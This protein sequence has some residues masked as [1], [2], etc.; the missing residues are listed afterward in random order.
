MFE[1]AQQIYNAYCLHGVLPDTAPKDD[2]R[3]LVSVFGGHTALL[4]TATRE[5]LSATGSISQESSSP[6]ASNSLAANPDFHPSWVTFARLEIQKWLI[7]RLQPFMG[8]FPA[9]AFA[10]D[11]DPSGNNNNSTIIP[12]FPT[13]FDSYTYP[14]TI[15]TLQTP[16]ALNGIGNQSEISDGSDSSSTYPNNGNRNPMFPAFSP[17]EEMVTVGLDDMMMGLVPDMSGIP[18]SDQE[19]QAFLLNS[20]NVFA[21]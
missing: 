21:T 4:D 13:N 8:F 7:L 1:R 12:S 15:G 18:E 9:S 10:P 17:S 2:T 6:T 19:W 5:D 16:I 20:G 14:E 11:F 3:D